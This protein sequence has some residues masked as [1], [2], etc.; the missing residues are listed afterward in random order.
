MLKLPSQILEQWQQTSLRSFGVLVYRKLTI[1]RDVPSPDGGREWRDP[2]F[3][4]SSFIDLADAELVEQQVKLNIE[5][6]LSD[7]VAE[8]AILLPPLFIR[9]NETLIIEYLPPHV[10]LFACECGP[11]VPVFTR[12]SEDTLH[13]IIDLYS[14]VSDKF[15]NGQTAAELLHI[16]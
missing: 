8:E 10:Y 14:L 9:S 4:V 15:F 16:S 7:D 13:C 6:V 5:Q 1:A 12:L 11:V 3:F 2:S